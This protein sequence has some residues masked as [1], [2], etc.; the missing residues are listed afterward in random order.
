MNVVETLAFYCMLLVAVATVA[1]VFTG[2]LQ[3]FA[4]AVIAWVVVVLIGLVPVFV[5]A[6]RWLTQRAD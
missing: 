5:A 6:Y 3:L 2:N 1:W 4:A